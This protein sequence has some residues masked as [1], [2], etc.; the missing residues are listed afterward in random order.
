M[1]DQQTYLLNGLLARQFSLGR[2]V[3]FRHVAR[4][5]QAATFELLTA[6]QNEYLAYLYP[7]AFHAPQLQFMAD[8]VNRLDA[9]RFSVVPFLPSKDGPLVAEGP[10]NSHLLVS[11]AAPGSPLEPAQYT[12]HDISQVGLRLAWMH[13]LL[14]EQLNPPP[15][16]TPLKTLLTEALEDAP[17]DD[18]TLASFPPESRNALLSALDLP[19][20]SLAWAHG[21]LQPAALLHDSD[22]Q[23]R[24]LVDWA[25]L[26]PADPREDLIDAI[27]SLCTAPSA[28]GFLPHRAA[29]LLESYNTLSPL[30]SLPW[31]PAVAAWS[32]RRLLDALSHR[33]PLP[34]LLPTIA[35]TPER[36]ATTL[37][38]LT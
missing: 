9:Q 11:L 34:P 38:S 15:T 16:T 25:L 37:A 3:R 35:P 21:H 29:I 23:L 24:T 36:L 31:T 10:Q 22:H 19:P 12:D 13:R 7:H 14:K 17:P 18:P 28:A 6:Q 32:A 1:D 8:A 4:G 26:H 30:K 5:R 2:I 33:R 20:A 27:L